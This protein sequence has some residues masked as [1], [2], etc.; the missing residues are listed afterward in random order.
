MLE[1]NSKITVI[2]NEARDDG[3]APTVITFAEKCKRQEA[4]DQARASV[5]LEGFTPSAEREDAA[6][7]YVSGEIDIDGFLASASCAN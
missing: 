5:R 4:V 7:R 6:R 2:V 3:N 1:K